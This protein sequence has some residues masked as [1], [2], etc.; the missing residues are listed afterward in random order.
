MNPY[1]YHCEK[2]HRVKNLIISIFCSA[3]VAGVIALA[4]SAQSPPERPR[5]A[6]YVMGE[7]ARNALAPKS[8]KFLSDMQE[9]ITNVWIKN[10]P[11]SLNIANTKRV[12]IGLTLNRDGTIADHKTTVE[13]SSGDNAFDDAGLE[14]VRAAAPFKVPASAFTGSKIQLHVVFDDDVL[15]APM[16]TRVP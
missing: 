3:A 12:I 8:Y 9:Q 5:P 14:A 11:L 15:H 1:N 7:Q 4:M 16:G 2:T 13:Q 10:A 6:I